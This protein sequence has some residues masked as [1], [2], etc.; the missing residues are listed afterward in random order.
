MEDT[1]LFTLAIGLK[2]LWKIESIEMIDS[3]EG[4][5]QLHIRIGHDRGA[6][7]I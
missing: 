2:D 4:T 1:T 6:E 7:F 5:A 3:E